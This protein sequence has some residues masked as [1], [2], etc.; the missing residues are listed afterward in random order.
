MLLTQTFFACA[1]T[2]PTGYFPREMWTKSKILI[3]SLLE[4]LREKPVTPKIEVKEKTDDTE[5]GDLDQF[6]Q[7]TDA[8]IHPALVNFIEKLD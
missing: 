5:G 1:K 4:T 6:Q 3:E 8:Q 2:M 7:S